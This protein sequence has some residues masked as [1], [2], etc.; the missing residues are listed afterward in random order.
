MLGKDV[1]KNTKHTDWNDS[2]REDSPSPYEPRLSHATTYG[3]KTRS[4]VTLFKYGV[5]DVSSEDSNDNILGIYVSDSV[6]S[7]KVRHFIDYE[8]FSNPFFKYKTLKSPAA[9]LK[10]EMTPTENTDTRDLKEEL[11]D[12]KVVRASTEKFP[13]QRSKPEFVSHLQLTGDKPIDS[14]R[15]SIL[16]EIEKVEE[17]LPPDPRIVIPYGTYYM[18]E[19]TLAVNNDDALDPTLSQAFKT[20][21]V[22][23]HQNL[24]DL[25]SVLSK[26]K[27]MATPEK[28]V[29]PE[30]IGRLS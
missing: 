13:Y 1:T 29:L 8:K 28:I 22:Q 18:H 3:L 6:N 10:S 9:N 30:N 12:C 27:P 24:H 16:A 7:R 2:F 15:E 23:N 19:M 5:T 17:V 11:R 14:P 20:H 4:N 21:V 25:L 26:E